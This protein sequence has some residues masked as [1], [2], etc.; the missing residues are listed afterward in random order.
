MRCST[1]RARQTVGVITPTRTVAAMT[2][3]VMAAAVVFGACTGG[4]DTTTETSTPTTVPGVT[5]VP[6]TPADLVNGYVLA[7]TDPLVASAGLAD[8]DAALYLEYRRLSAAA[9]GSVLTAL[10][11]TDTHQVCAENG[12]VLIGDLVVDPTTGRVVTFSVDGVPIAGRIGGPGLVADDDGVVAQV[13]TAYATNAGQVVVTVEIDNT[14]STDVE[15]FG[16][17]AVLQPVGAVGGVEATSAFGVPGVTAGA[18][19]D[20]L[21]VFDVEP[22]PD[23]SIAVGGRLSLFGLRSD[24][25]EVRLDIDVPEPAGGNGQLG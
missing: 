4:D 23:G 6:V 18:D 1:R 19:G 11:G 7:F 5:T 25:L 3:G 14:T 13:L 2:V 16:F 20:L 10:P 9:L 22:G 15:L 17:G 24:G 21:L 8:G 12:C